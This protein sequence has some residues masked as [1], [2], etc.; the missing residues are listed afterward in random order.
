MGPIAQSDGGDPPGL[1]DEA[2]PGEAAMAEDIA[3]GCEDAIGQLVVPHELP[4]VLDRVQL[5]R[6]RRQRQQGDVVGHWQLRRGVPAGLVEQED[7]MG[8]GRD[9]ARDLFQ[10][11]G[12]GVGGAAGQDQGGALSFGRAD[13][14]EDVD[15]AGSLIVRRRR[16]CAAARPAAGD[17]V[18]LAD[19]RLVLEPDLY[20]LAG[21]VARRDRRQDIG[22]VFGS[23]SVDC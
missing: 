5:R 4:D 7:G 15:R 18:L 3:V 14:A 11:Q 20:G 23:V 13:G 8:A 12:H 22:E 16:P 21:G 17:L 10:M 6:L 2:V 1:I 9:G 19:P